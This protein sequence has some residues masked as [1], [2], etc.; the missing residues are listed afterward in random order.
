MGFEKLPRPP[1]QKRSSIIAEQIVKR[2]RSNQYPAG[3]KLPPERLIAEQMGVS[4]PSVREAIS[5]LQIVGILQSRPG[6]GTYVA[7]SFGSDDL[8]RQAFEVLEESESPLVILQAR[9]AMEIGVA[10]V[11]ITVATD[12]DIANIERAWRERYEQGKRGDYTAFLKYGKT[13]HISIAQAT[14]N[15]VIVAIME[16]LLNATRQPLWTHMRRTYYE[17]RPE[18]IEMM[19]QVHHNIVEAVRRRDTDGAIAALEEHFDIL[20]N[21]IYTT[22]HESGSLSEDERSEGEQTLPAGEERLTK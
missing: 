3:A 4:R 10:R 6:D 21:Q 20:V 16:N 2:V 7:D 5:A 11:A 22:S 19:L 15:H 9:K 17:G 14:N 1:F 13:F 12:E 18:R 8:V